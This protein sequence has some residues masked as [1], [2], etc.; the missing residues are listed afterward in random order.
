MCGS[1]NEFQQ[2]CSIA[3]SL[4][5]RSCWVS[6]WTSLVGDMIYCGHSH[7]P[8]D[9]TSIIIIYAQSPKL[10][11]SLYYFVC[12]DFFKVCFPEQCIHWEPGVRLTVDPFLLL[13]SFPFVI[14][15]LC[16]RE[17]MTIPTT[18]LMIL[19]FMWSFR[20]IFIIRP[21]YKWRSSICHLP[22]RQ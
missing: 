20:L 8:V 19:P 16:F 9:T 13:A 21:I 3:Q 5:S 10:L 11:L 7:S 6:L 1:L 2:T 22:N 14:G 12:S 17:T 18:S 4:F 15:L